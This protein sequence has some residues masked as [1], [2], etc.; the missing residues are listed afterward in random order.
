MAAAIPPVAQSHDYSGDVSAGSLFDVFVKPVVEF[1][2][3]WHLVRSKQPKEN[4]KKL[5]KYAAV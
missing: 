4:K 3:S 2:P 1:I 5:G